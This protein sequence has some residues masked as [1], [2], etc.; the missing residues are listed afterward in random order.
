MA[1]H[2]ATSSHLCLPRW[3][4]PRTPERPTYGGRVA[5]LAQALGLPLMPWQKQIA[6]V[7]FEIMPDTGRPAYRVVRVAVPRQSGKTTLV[8][9]IQVDR[10]L[11]W[12]DLQHT[13]YTAQDRNHSRE[14]WEEQTEYLRRTV[15][16]KQFLQR[17]QT[18]MER[19]VWKATGSV[20]GITAS[21]ETSG[22]GGTLD[23]GIVDEAWAQKDERLAA[24]FRPAMMTR[25]HAQ[26]WW[27]STMGTEDSIPWNDRVDDGRARVEAQL[28]EPSEC[29]G[30]AYFEWSAPDDDDPYNEETWWRCMPALG[31]TV[32]VQTVWTDARSLPEADFRRGYLNQRTVGGRPVIEPGMWPK[33]K[34]LEVQVGQ[35]IVFGVD[36]TPDRQFASIVACGWADG[37]GRT[38]IELIDHRPGVGWLVPRLAE[39]AAKWKPLTIVADRASPAGKLTH[40]LETLG[41]P[42]MATDTGQYAGACG[43]FYDAVLDGM[44]YHRGQAPL[45]AAIASARKRQIGDTWAWARRE[46]GDVSPLVAATLARYGLAFMG[47]GDFRIF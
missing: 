43:A 36:A 17:R 32:D 15:L 20:V 47:Q 10:S 34:N 9:V 41:L 18:G 42:T 40:E 33:L 11:N 44:V 30:V 35:V 45:D 22:H 16:R 31:V 1:P 3:A 46:G 29:K 28:L 19:T 25:R 12:G 23:L 4:T 2:S 8:L 24:A 38:A 21:G 27:L 13:L 5:K 37:S 26:E 7:A 6:N 14:K 39:L